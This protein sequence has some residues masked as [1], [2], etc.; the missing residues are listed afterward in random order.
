[1]VFRVQYTTRAAFQAAGDPEDAHWRDVA[2]LFED[3]KTADAEAA[4]LSIVAE[5]R[6]VYRVIGFELV[7]A[8]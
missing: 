5:G 7:R 1:M 3:E 4:D 2:G 6:F 8:A